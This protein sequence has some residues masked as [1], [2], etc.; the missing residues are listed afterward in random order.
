MKSS[1]PPGTQTGNKRNP[2]N[3]IKVSNAIW[4]ILIGLAAVIWLL[5]RDFDPEIFKDIRFTWQ[6]ACWILVALLF[7]V[8]RDLGYM[9]R[10]RVLSDWKL[11]W[12]QAFR[13]VMLWEFTSAVTPGAV[14]GTSV[15][16]IYVH[17]E[18]ISVGRSSAIVMVTSLLDEFYF[19]F[20]FPLLLLLV[21]M[22]ELFAIPDSPGWTHGLIMVALIGY[23][24]KLIWVLVLSYGLFLNPRGLSKLIYRI[25]HLPLLRR[26]RRGAGKAAL[27]IVVSSKEMKSRKPKFWINALL[28]TFLSWTSR[29]W[30]VNFMFL[31]FFAVHDHFLIFARQL[32]M[33]IILLVSPTPGGSGVAEFTFDIFLGDFIPIAG[34]AIALT[35]LWRLISYYPYLAIGAIMFPRWMKRHFSRKQHEV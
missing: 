6:T 14:G 22:G 15:A 23:S 35:F 20:M 25:F 16:T 13:V 10:I 34:F 2:L 33:S 18:G 30:V 28:S 24:I 7:M 1:P 27:D 4:P 11:T 17:K 5:Q 31:A 26:W 3:R 19:V 9:I 32:V 8:G 12:L 21:G 29:Y